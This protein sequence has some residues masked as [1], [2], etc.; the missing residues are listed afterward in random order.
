MVYVYDNFEQKMDRTKDGF[1]FV[2]DPA[3]KTFIPTRFSD[4]VADANDFDSFSP[5]L[6]WERKI[7]EGL[8]GNLRATYSEK[9]GG[10]S[11]YTVTDNQITFDEEE[12]F[13][14]KSVYYSLLRIVN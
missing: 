10:F 9:P 7:T 2:F 1:N 5:T 14:M 6:N 11:A 4:T 13:R 8:T 12:N 3:L